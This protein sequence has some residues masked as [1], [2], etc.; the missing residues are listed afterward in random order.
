MNVDKSRSRKDSVG[1]FGS[2]IHWGLDQGASFRQSSINPSDIDHN[3]LDIKAK[4]S[5]FSS[6][7]DGK[8]IGNFLMNIANMI[9]K[10]LGSR[11]RHSSNYYKKRRS[12]EHPKR[13]IHE[14]SESSSD[15]DHDKSREKTTADDDMYMGKADEKKRNQRKV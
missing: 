11:Q 12:L 4:R 2:R 6:K 5:R 8:M 10:K 7:N 1:G 9:Q 13:R 15:D 3:P 14:D